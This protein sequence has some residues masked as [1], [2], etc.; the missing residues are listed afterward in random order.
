MHSLVQY[1]NKIGAICTGVNLVVFI[2]CTERPPQSRGIENGFIFT[3]ITNRKT[4]H[5]R[6]NQTGPIT[7]VSPFTCSTR[8][9]EQ[10]QS[11]TPFIVIL[12]GLPVL[13]G[14]HVY[15]RATELPQRYKVEKMISFSVFIV[16]RELLNWSA[17]QNEAVL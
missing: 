13:V 10:Q 1:I 16:M 17:N 8:D 6:I 12:V 4:H 7:T 3:V 15:R 9:Y 5:F 11:A 14:Y 2:D